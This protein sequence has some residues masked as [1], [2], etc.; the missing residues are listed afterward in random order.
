MVC[1][2]GSPR[3]EP[4]SRGFL[5]LVL[6]AASRCL[7]YTLLTSPL[8]L[9]AGHSPETSCRKGL[10]R[11]SLPRLHHP[12][13]PGVLWGCSSGSDFLRGS[14]KGHFRDSEKAGKARQSV[15]G[16]RD[17]RERADMCRTEE[18]LGGRERG[19]GNE[20]G[21]KGEGSILEELSTQPLEEGLGLGLHPT[22]DSYKL[23]GFS[24]MTQPLC[25]LR[26]I[27]KLKV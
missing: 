20:P 2:P 13:G 6:G 23:C 1:P 3:K 22:S 8:V 11:T 19:E 16:W 17:W 4:E 15:K 9:A 21:R 18:E 10:P 5:G 25:F 12:P 7:C 14:R 24:Q 26:F 27:C